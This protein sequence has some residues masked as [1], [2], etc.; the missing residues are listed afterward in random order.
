MRRDIELAV[1]KPS[2]GPLKV[3]NAGYRTLATWSATRKIAKGRRYR[4]ISLSA[5][6]RLGIPVDEIECWK[7]RVRCADGQSRH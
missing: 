3:I 7:N 6:Y 4:H 2:I 1:I 5:A